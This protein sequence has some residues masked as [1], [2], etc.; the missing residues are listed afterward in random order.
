MLSPVVTPCEPESLEETGLAESTVEQNILRI[1]YFRGELYGKDLSIAIGLRFSVIQD[2]V[3][4]LKLSHHLQVKRSMGMGNVGSVFA[5]TESGR[6][7]ARQYLESNQYSGPAPVPAEQY[8]DIVRRQRQ[9]DG[10][11]TKE[12]LA[13]AFR[14]MVLTE[15]ILTQVGPAVSAGNSL[16]LYGKP[17][18]GKTYLIESLANLDTAPIFVPYAIECQGNIV[19]VFDPIYHHLVEEAPAESTEGVSIFH[20]ASP[21]DRRWAKCKRPFIV[22]GGELSLEMLDLRYNHTSKV[23]EAPF[24]LK[25]NNGIYLIDDFGRQR[26]TPAEVLNRWIVPMERRQDYLSFLTGGKMVVPFELFLVFSTN[27]N[28]ADLGDEAFLRRIQYKMLL[29]GPSEKE[30]IRIFEDCTAKRRVP[31]PPELLERFLDKHYRSTGKVFRRCHPRDLLSHALNLIHFEKRPNELTEEILDTA[32]KGCFLEENANEEIPDAPILPMEA[33]SS[34]CPEYWA[35]KI[36]AAGTSFGLLALLG[37]ARDAE[38]GQYHDEESAGQF[39]AEETTRVLEELH[40]RQFEEWRMMGRDGQTRDI[41]KYLESSP[42]TPAGFKSQLE[43]WVGV[44]VPADSADEDRCMFSHDL[45]MVA[46]RLAPTPV[47][48][49]TLIVASA[50]MVESTASVESTPIAIAPPEGLDLTARLHRLADN[51]LR[52]GAESAAA[53]S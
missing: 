5:L 37:Q 40:R 50:A 10:W 41:G 52:G 7:L 31:C 13:K 39:G 34:G 30:F 23:Y 44:L 6:E 19:Q 47:E 8:A 3:E 38:R 51:Q 11:L 2:I 17:G 53:A 21:Y 15:S 25:A 46:E 29:R 16:L 4:A 27:L 35:E 49:A 20:D 24:Q 26:A 28:P 12:E 48:E 43:E 33:V 32:F 14:G 45:A 18:D 1:L 36:A 42:L 9:R 22:S